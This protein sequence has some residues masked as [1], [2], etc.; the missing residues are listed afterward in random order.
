MTDQQSNLLPCPLCGGE[1]LYTEA[2][3]YGDPDIIEHSP[4]TGG[5]SCPLNEVSNFNI[6]TDLITAWNTRKPDAFR[7]DNG[8]KGRENPA[9]AP[10]NRNTDPIWQALWELAEDAN[11]PHELS[12]GEMV[13]RAWRKFVGEMP[14]QDELTDSMIE[15]TLK[16][17]KVKPT[18]CLNGNGPDNPTHYSVR[19]FNAIRELVSHP[20]PHRSQK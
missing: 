13:D 9:E 7:E 16:K 12:R 1:M 18:L 6:D 15:T 17:H 19:I 11:G 3:C 14:A 2:R 8:D 5:Y 10:T 4:V 20:H